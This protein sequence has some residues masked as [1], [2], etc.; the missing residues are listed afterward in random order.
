[1][2][3]SRPPGRERDPRS[4]TI[5]TRPVRGARGPQPEHTRD[6]IAAAAI[7]L[8]DAGGLPAASMRAI[9][10]A[11]GT[12]GGTLYRY[13]SSRD[14]LLDLM[15]D[16]ALAELPDSRASLQTDWLD[17]VVALAT[18][19]LA[20]YR[21]HPWLLAVDLPARTLGPHGLDY[22][23]RCLAILTPVEAGTVTKM[24]AIAMITGV[25]SLFVR[26]EAGARSRS[27]SPAQLFAA[28]TPERHPHLVAALSQ[29]GPPAAGGAELFER[30]L[31]SLLR[32][33]LSTA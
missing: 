31:R 14:D 7:T 30:T 4:E 12:S 25:V 1:M 10:A 8:A 3:S 19:V 20:L 26:N 28:A 2:T 32:G 29:P 23:D 5:W 13:L 9:A 6:Q 11:L 21:R 17:E 24:E 27:V 16:A 15:L 22:F 33:L 18:E